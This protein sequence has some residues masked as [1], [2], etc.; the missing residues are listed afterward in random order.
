MHDDGEGVA[1]LRPPQ[2]PAR[3]QPT[4]QVE[5]RSLPRRSPT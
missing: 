4:F 5:R 3:R 1:S 2:Q